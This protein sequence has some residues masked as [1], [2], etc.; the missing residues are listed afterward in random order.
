M[1]EISRKIQMDIKG[2]VSVSKTCSGKDNGTG[3]RHSIKITGTG[4]TTVEAK[5]S[6]NKKLR[7]HKLSQTYLNSTHSAS[8]YWF[9][10][11][12]VPGSK[13]LPGCLYTLK[14]EG[15]IYGI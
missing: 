9:D 4:P 3:I 13:K 12:I 6:F 11:F 15:E 14:K 10:I 5:A 7:S 2:G 1:K 8:Y